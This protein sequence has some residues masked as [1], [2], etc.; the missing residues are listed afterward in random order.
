MKIVI[1]ARLYGLEHRGIGRYVI[2]LTKELKNLKTKE[3]FVILLRKK[4]FNKLDFPNN[5]EKVLA[6]FQHYSLAEQL[7]LS[8]LVSKY[9]PDIV[10]FP[11]FNTPLLYKEKFVVTIHDMSMHKQGRDA[12]NL[13]L[14]LYY[15]KRFPYGYVFR[16]AVESS[17][18]IITPTKAI[19][20][21][22]VDYYKID[23]DKVTVTYEGI[24]P[25]FKK[26]FT[27]AN[28]VLKKYQLSAQKY[29]IYVGNVYP[30]KN[31]KRAIEAIGLLNR[32]RS[33]QVKLAIVSSRDLFTK[34]LE[35]TI[36]K[37]QAD[38]YI[39]L[40]GFVPDDEL[41]ILLRQSLAFV[42]PSLAEGF[43]LP[44]LEALSAGTLLL[45]SDIPVFKEVYKKSCIYFNP[46]DF[47]SI[48]KTMEEVV[49]M[50]KSERERIIKSSKKFINRYS[51]SKMANQTL[52]VY[53]DS[54]RLRSGE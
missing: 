46:F 14:P 39:K 53:E 40:L 41:G 54:Y 26:K 18:K 36:K 32:R 5:W 35:K 27:G 10:H 24:D 43:G 8:R 47:T 51:W 33:E 29:F 23:E 2:N 6:D 38:D 9:K 20:K 22:V 3:Q 52:K 12:T 25:K 21:D 48:T 31:V 49:K 4:Y 45:A 19:K 17:V 11:H 37:M 50:T 34:R 13:P 30:H 44:G 1:D 15:A 7:K 16:N 42:Y 28:K